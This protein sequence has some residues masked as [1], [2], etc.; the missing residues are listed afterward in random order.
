MSDHDVTRRQFLNYTLLGV[1]GF[2]AAG[3]VLPMARFAIDPLLQDHTTA[4]GFTKIDLKE[5]DLTNE[6]QKAS[7]TVKD[8]K[9][10]WYKFDEDKTA[11]VFKTEDGEILA[12]SPI[13]TH[14]G[15]TVSWSPEPPHTAEF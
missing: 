3:L 13:C 11:Y 12:L 1:G 10:G 9:D 8:V 5:K 2:M 6:P 4:G 7:F 14:L 15:C